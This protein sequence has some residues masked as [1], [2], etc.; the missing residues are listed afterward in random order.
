M[1][2]LSILFIS[3][4]STLGLSAHCQVPCG[5]YNDPA[6]IQ[7]MLEDAQ[8]V[9]K[10]SNQINS[11]ADKS[12]AQSV[13]QIVRWVDN[14][15]SHAQ[16][17]IHTISDYFLTQRVKTTQEDYSTRL[18]DHHK[19]ILC[20][21]AVKQHSSADLSKEL[22]EAIEVLKKYYPTKEKE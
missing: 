2:Y 19:V 12:D 17:I 3:L 6:R 9:T 1:K 14:K 7:S 16:S 18:A 10:A 11:L 21:M 4:I 5:I 8:T 13:N 15:E 22:T 20:A